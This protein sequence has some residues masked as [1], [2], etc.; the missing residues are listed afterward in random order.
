MIGSRVL[1]GTLKKLSIKYLLELAEDSE[2][3]VPVTITRSSSQQVNEVAALA[4]IE[5][6]MFPLDPSAIGGVRDAELIRNWKVVPS[7]VDMYI[8]FKVNGITRR[9]YI[10]DDETFIGRTTLSLKDGGYF[11]VLGGATPGRL[12]VESEADH[13]FYVPESTRQKAIQILGGEAGRTLTVS[14]DASTASGIEYDSS[15]SSP[16]QAYYLLSGVL[17]SLH[18]EPSL[19]Q[20]YLLKDSTM[21]YRLIDT[22]TPEGQAEADEY[23]RYKANKRIFVIDHEDLI[24]D[25]IEETSSVSLTQ[26]D[27]LFDS[28]KENKNIPLLTRQIPWYIMVV[29]T[30]RSDYNLF[31]SKS[32]ILSITRDG[33][34]SRELRCK[35][36]IVPEFSKRQTNKFI[37]YSTVDR[38]GVDVLGNKNTQARQTIIEVNDSDFKKT[39][40]V[41]GK[42]VGTDE[43]T[44]NRDKTPIRIVR[45]IINELDT[46]YELSLNG[47]GKSLTEFDVFSRLTVKQFNKLSRLESFDLI[48][49]S[50][51]NGLI[52]NVKLIPPVSKADNRISFKKTQLVQRKKAAGEDTFKQIKATNIGENIV[53]PDTDGVGGF[54]PAS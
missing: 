54:T 13:A 26:T 37:K 38:D 20:S 11:D 14:A 23:I 43:Y 46:N 45:E 35:T 24:L 36:S 51:Q 53:S 18:T 39:Y 34:M 12:F 31:N 25:Y 9:F 48:K 52:N 17:S 22:V 32:R 21:E 30:N 16:R 3:R 49:R 44:P 8:P 29:P 1:D 5:K 47:I 42:L 7:D 41:G 33:A 28:P 40:S 6:N 27:I 2:K 15:L 10:N 50:I 4:L 19:G